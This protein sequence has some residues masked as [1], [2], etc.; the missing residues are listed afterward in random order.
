M[1]EGL[2]QGQSGVGLINTWDTN[3]IRLDVSKDINVLNTIFQASQNYKPFPQ[4]GSVNLISNFGHNTYHAATA[5]VEKRYSGGLIFNAFYTFQKTI[6]DNEG[7][8]GVG[9]VTITTAALRKAWRLTT[10]STAS[11]PS[12]PM[13]TVRQRPALLQSEPPGRSGRRRVGTYMD[14]DFSGGAALHRWLL[15][16]SESAASHRRAAPQHCDHHAAG[17]G[18]GLGTGRESLPYLGTESLL[19][20]QFVRLSGCL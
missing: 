19:E 8:G 1:L 6:T 3:R 9:G 16:Q 7:E 20:L 13:I 18:P 10:S 17:R 15:Q 5:R 4:F 14:A 12:C 2:Y 11:F